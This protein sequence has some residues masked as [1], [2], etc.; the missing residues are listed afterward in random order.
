MPK[1]KLTLSVDDAVISK[2]KRY[3]LRHQTSVSRLVTEFLASLEDTEGRS[4]PIVAKLRGVIRSDASKDEYH[5]YLR[6]KHSS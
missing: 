5:D 6:H 3:S 4:A 2:A 1:T